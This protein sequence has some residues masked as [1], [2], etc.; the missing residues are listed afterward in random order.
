MMRRALILL[1]HG[2]VIA[3]SMAVAF[4]IIQSFGPDVLLLYDQKTTQQ[5][6]A[7]RGQFY[8]LRDLPLQ[9]PSLARFHWGVAGFNGQPQG[10]YGAFSFPLWPAALVLFAPTG[11]GR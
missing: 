4:V 2:I 9:C 11:A 10:D 5:Y 6:F 3:A 1:A 7:Y 8:V